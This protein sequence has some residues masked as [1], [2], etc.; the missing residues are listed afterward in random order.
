[1][2][3]RAP[4]AGDVEPLVEMGLR[5]HAESA[6][7]FLPY[8]RNKVIRLVQ[9]FLDD[10]SSRCGLVAEADGKLVGML[11]GYLSEYFF[12]SEVVAC[13]MVLFVDPAYRHGLAAMRLVRA[14]RKW[15]IEHGARELCLAIS[16][17]VN[18][19]DT[20]RFYERLGFTRVG[21]VYKQ[22]LR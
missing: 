3:I 6:Y 13:D 17:N 1:M 22:R 20:G 12:C 7:A 14:F 15:A 11:G 10:S 8:E 9:S 5:M 21:G 19:D 2:R 16:T 18:A 4:V